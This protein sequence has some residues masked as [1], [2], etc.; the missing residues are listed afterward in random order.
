M[1]P[2]IT[3]LPV[4]NSPNFMG[5]NRDS[6]S[7]GGCF[8]CLISNLEIGSWLGGSAGNALI[9]WSFRPVVNK[10]HCSLLGEWYMWFWTISIFLMTMLK[11]YIVMDIQNGFPVVNFQIFGIFFCS[12]G[13][14]LRVLIGIWIFNFYAEFLGQ[15][16]RIFELY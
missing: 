16:D 11:T 14:L 1:G 9:S 4:A 3:G 8:S 12:S 2:L 6:Y 7:G 5:M 13:F 10:Y 15:K